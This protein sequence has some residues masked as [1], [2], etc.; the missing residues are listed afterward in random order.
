MPGKACASTP[1]APGSLASSTSRGNLS[2]WARDADQHEFCELVR[3]GK[4]AQVKDALE[5]QPNLAH[6]RDKG[7]IPVLMIA[8][9][10]ER[11]I[12]TRLLVQHGAIPTVKCQIPGRETHTPLAA[13]LRQSRPFITKL[14]VERYLQIEFFDK[15]MFLSL[16][17]LVDNFPLPWEKRILRRALVEIYA[18][19]HVTFMLHGIARDFRAQ[20]A[21]TL[22]D[23]IELA[24]ATQ[25]MS[26][27]IKHYDPLRADQLIMSSNK[28]QLAASACVHS[29]GN[30]K[31]GLGRYV[32]AAS[33]S[34]SL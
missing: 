21:Q 10:D 9:E 1:T 2:N 34:G 3:K 14:L 24:A 29:L 4:T 22:L 7:G 16:R 27:R 12:M 30:L 26:L 32:R 23:L 20:P 18:D 13:S 6:A 5:G 11:P 28:L 8:V 17:Q 33:A 31:D 15:N 25:R 19:M